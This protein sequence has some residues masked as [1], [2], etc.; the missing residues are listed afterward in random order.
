[1]S[2]RHNRTVIAT[3][4]EEIRLKKG[5]SQEEV[6]RAAGISRAAYTN[7]E[8]GRRRPSPEVAQK[9]AKFLK[10]NW[11]WFFVKWKYQ[12]GKASDGQKDTDGHDIDGLEER[13]EVG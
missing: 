4:L 6:A 13:K 12:A 9:I 10:F 7:I 5:H 11:T 1:M 2:Q 8:L 3:S